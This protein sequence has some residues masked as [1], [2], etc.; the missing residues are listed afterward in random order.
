MCRTQWWLS[1]FTDRNCL[2]WCNPNTRQAIHNCVRTALP[3]VANWLYTRS[4]AVSVLFALC[5][6]IQHTNVEIIWHWSPECYMKSEMSSHDGVVS[7]TRCDVDENCALLGCYAAHSGKSLLTFRGN[8]SFPF[9]LQESRNPTFLT[10][11][12]R[13]DRF[14]RNVGKDLPLYAV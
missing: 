6:Y 2:Q 13:T 8:L 11:E 4:Y 5:K 1:L 14:S 12:D 9:R 10:L 3:T 7:G